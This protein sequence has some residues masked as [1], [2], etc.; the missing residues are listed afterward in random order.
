MASA[1]G[2]VLLH[3]LPELMAARVVV[4]AAVDL[5]YMVALDARL[6]IVDSPWEWRKVSITRTCYGWWDSVS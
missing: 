4:E 6:S 3:L 1:G 5:S 2:Y